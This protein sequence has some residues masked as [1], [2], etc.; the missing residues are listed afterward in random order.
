M[1]EAA[2]PLAFP[3][4]DDDGF[5]PTLP[6]STKKAAAIASSIMPAARIVWNLN[7]NRGEA[8]CEVINNSDVAILTGYNAMLRGLTENLKRPS[9]KLHQ[10]DGR[11]HRTDHFDPP[12][13]ERK[14]A[15][16]RAVTA[17]REPQSS[18]HKMKRRKGSP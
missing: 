10:L 5:R 1:T 12:D 4:V 9:R 3:T 6:W 18:A 16:S 2:G 17:R 14:H 7:T 11:Y 15:A 8:R 13:P